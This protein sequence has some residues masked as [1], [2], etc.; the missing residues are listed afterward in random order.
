MKPTPG[1]DSRRSAHE[2]LIA[3]TGDHERRADRQDCGIGEH[4]R[5]HRDIIR[6]EVAGAAATASATAPP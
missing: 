4:G 1:G 2:I 6:A 5:I 3:G